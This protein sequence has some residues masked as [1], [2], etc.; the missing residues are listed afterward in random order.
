MPKPAESPPDGTASISLG[1]TGDE[2]FDLL[3]AHLELGRGFSL[4]LLAVPGPLVLDEIER[5]L[6]ARWQNAFCRLHFT[7][8]N[9]LA[10]LPERLRDLGSGRAGQGGADRSIVLISAAGARDDVVA[11]WANVLALLNERRNWL[12]EVCPHALIFAG[13]E[14]LPLV[15]HDRA[16]DL[17]SVRSSV[18]VFPDAPPGDGGLQQ[19]HL[20][21]WDTTWPLSNELQDGERYLELAEALAANPREGEQAA[22]GRLLAKAADAWKLRGKPDRAMDALNQAVEIFDRLGDVRSRAVTMGKLADILC[23]R[24][25]VD[26]AERILR[27]EVLPA[28]KRLGDVRERAVTLSKVADILESRGELDEVERIL[29][30]EVLPAFDRLGD[31]RERAVALGRTAD[32]LSRRGELDE[33]ERILREKVLPVFERLGDVRSRAVTLGRVADILESRG[34]LDEGERIRR[35]EELP[36]FE[37]LGDVRERAVTMG[38]IADILCRRGELD[39]AV[40]LHKERLQVFQTLRDVDGIAN[41]HWAVGKIELRQGR[42]ESAVK[43]LTESYRLTQKLGRLDG[44]CIVGAALGQLLCGADA[45]KEGLEIL[46][47][48]RDGYVKLGQEGRAAELD[49]LIAG[50]QEDGGQD[51]AGGRATPG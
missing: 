44:I 29:R 7:K 47:R 10:E 23:R 40:K 3:S 48:S 27:E 37:R 42:R 17:W 51:H 34:E 2:Q 43:S 35:E 24:G 33:A 11:G 16:P 28:F 50:I 31:V 19:H 46:R 13:P 14:Q 15:A 6:E 25:E 20:A 39:E 4:F 30:E 21:S 41:T 8:A 45:K 38:K 18:I 9:G 26:E 5:R 32:I 12:M 49:K 36:V 22:R 1:K